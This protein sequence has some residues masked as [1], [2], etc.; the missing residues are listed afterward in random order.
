MGFPTAVPSYASACS[1]TVRYSSACACIGVTGSTTTVTPA[2]TV[3]TVTV[4]VT[5]IPTVVVSVTAIETLPVT[6]TQAS[7]VIVTETAVATI[8]DLVSSVVIET[9]VVPTT[10]TATVDVAAPVCTT[11]A[12]QAESGDYQGLYVDAS[13]GMLVFT[14][15]D[16]SRGIF[17]YDPTTRL[18]TV[19][20]APGLSGLPLSTEVN[21]S[22]DSNS[23]WVSAA[24][25]LSPLD[26][27]LTV[28][29]AAG[30][31]AQSFDCTT[32]IGYNYL[33]TCYSYQGLP[34]IA[35]EYPSSFGPCELLSL[36]V[37]PVC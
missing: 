19:L 13:S 18:V 1:G 4:S 10:T 25:G 27:T 6:V 3:S 33:Y 36:N 30:I 23:N 35:S 17:V 16:E 37:I 9:V 32:S 22:F 12:L 28:D 24:D 5:S 26:C 29:P 14:S 7:E 34:L 11:F 8:T 2:A 21:L 20:N 31:L 15:A